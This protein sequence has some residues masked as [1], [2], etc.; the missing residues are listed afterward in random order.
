MEALC[1]YSEVGMRHRVLGR[2][3]NLGFGTGGRG[4]WWEETQSW[5]AL[6]IACRRAGRQGSPPPPG[7]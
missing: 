7:T 2:A 3:R 6:A 5:S 1:E 4:E